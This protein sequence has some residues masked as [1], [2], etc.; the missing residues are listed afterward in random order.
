MEKKVS[1][2]KEYF[3]SPFNINLLNIL[4]SFIVKDSFN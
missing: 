1:L 4:K 3:Y 2:L